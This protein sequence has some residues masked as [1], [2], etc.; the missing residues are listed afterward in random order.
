MDCS[1][2]SLLLALAATLCA[3]SPPAGAGPVTPATLG[4]A[5]AKAAP[6]DTLVL[7]PGSYGEVDFSR[8]FAK[9]VTITCADKAHPPSFNK[10]SVTGGSYLTLSCLN[11]DFIPDAKTVTYSWATRIQDSDHI[12][13]KG[14]RIV[15]G[16]AVAGLNEDGSGTDVG[17]NIVGR[18][19][20]YGVLINH[21]SDVLIDGGEVASFHK[22]VM[23]QWTQKVTIRGVELHDMRTT[24]IVGADNSDLTIENN[25]LHSAHPW[26]WGNGDHADLLALWSNGNQATPNARVRIVNNRMEQ[27]EGEAILGMWMMGSQAAP[28]TD[29]EITGNQIVVNNL[30]GILINNTHGGVIADNRLYRATKGDDEQSPTVLLRENTTGVT[31][32]DNQLGAGISDLSEGKNPAKGNNV[33]RGDRN[34]FKKGDQP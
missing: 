5:F 8:R 24:A 4:A 2:K 25:Y 6:G 1:M 22:G 15:G 30:Q 29:V 7:A 9:P 11:V 23:L 27:L 18:P 33:I 32:R 20:A 21:A 13:L 19:T 17:G 3:C 10:L 14:V 28:F 31:L 16:K 34:I 12:T 26:R